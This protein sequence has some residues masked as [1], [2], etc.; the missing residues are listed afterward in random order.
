MKDTFNRLFEESIKKYWETPVFTDYRKETLTYG[1]VVKKILLLH[2]VFKGRSIKPGEKIALIGPN[3]AN[4]AIVYLATVTYGAVIVPI[5]FDFHDDDIQHILNHSESQV[6]FATEAIAAK[7][8]EERMARLKAVVSL[9]TLGLLSS[10][11]K[12]LPGEV[13]EIEEEAREK[14]A[15][16]TAESF[17]LPPD[18]NDSSL[19]ALVYTSGTSGFSKGVMLPYR[20]LMANIIYARENLRLNMAE[21]TLSFLPLAHAYACT[22][23]LLFPFTVGCHITFLEQIPSPKILIEAFAEV[24]PSLILFVPLILEKLYKKKLAPLLN[25]NSMK[26]LLKIPLLRRLICNK[27]RRRLDE[28]FGGNFKEIIIGGAALNAEV[29]AFLKKIKLPITVGYGITECG[30]L[31]SYA[32]WYEHRSRSVGRAIT[33]LKLKIDS[34]DQLSRVGEIMVRGEN[35]MLGYYKNKEA[36]GEVLDEEGWLRTGD[37]GVVDKDGFIYIRG[38][39][40]SLILGPSGQ[41]IYPEEIESKLNAMPYIQESLVLEENGRLI[42]LVY[43]D[44]DAVDAKRGGREDNEEWLRA[45]IEENKVEVNSRLPVYSRIAEARLHGDAFEKTPTH[46]IKRYRYS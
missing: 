18:R 42:A 30:P 20:S 36:T 29:E 40:K 4:W 15:G 2:A 28:T 22:F 21:Q 33:P 23:D 31:I 13:R 35:V 37:L 38:R 45:R 39:S 12:R 1:E 43:P 44:W 41:N 34:S 24:R 7:I 6:L 11:D 9:D 46:K 32:P 5:L 27:I 3:S 17:T 14:I 16:V 10:R 8:D 25:R 26:V 19:A